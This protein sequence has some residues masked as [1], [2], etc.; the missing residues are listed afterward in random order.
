MCW[1]RG[2]GDANFEWQPYLSHSTRFAAEREVGGATALI[3]GMILRFEVGSAKVPIASLD[4]LEELA[5]AKRRVV[6]VNP[7]RR[8][9]VSGHTDEV[10]GPDANLAL[11]RDRAA[12]I[13]AALMAHGVPASRLKVAG[14]GNAQ[15][16]R[17]GSTP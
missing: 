2:P 12:Q 15:P 11:S 16:L 6:A 1:L 9:T 4:R 5:A 7:S 14:A 17:T 8:I 3:E 13:A 10:G